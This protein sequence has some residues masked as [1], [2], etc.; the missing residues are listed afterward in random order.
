MQTMQLSVLRNNVTSSPREILQALIA[1][2]W[3]WKVYTNKRCV[4]NDNI[5]ILTRDGFEY[6]IYSD[7][8]TWMHVLSMFKA[9]GIYIGKSYSI[10]ESNCI[11]PEDIAAAQPTALRSLAN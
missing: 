4:T 9:Y 6:I 2:G 5:I 11:R 7:R 3:G 10:T 8:L 1:D